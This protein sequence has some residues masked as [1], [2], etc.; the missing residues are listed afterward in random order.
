MWPREAETESNTRR[1]VS[2]PSIVTRHYFIRMHTAA[3]H[4]V[5]E[6]KTLA[7]Y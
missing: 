1:L 4:L 2:S 7:V 5:R 6:L 3:K